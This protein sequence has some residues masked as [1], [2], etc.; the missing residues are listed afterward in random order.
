MH[1]CACAYVCEVL[2]CVHVHICVCV[3]VCTCTD[4]QEISGMC[5][6]AYMFVC[7]WAP[8]AALIVHMY[9]YMWVFMRSHKGV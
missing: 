8:M 2:V 5:A 9:E 3:S 4:R 1:V 7:V 6:Q